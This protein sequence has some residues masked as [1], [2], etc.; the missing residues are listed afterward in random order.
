[1]P[2]RRKV[3]TESGVNVVTTR[4]MSRREAEE[5]LAEDWELCSKCAIYS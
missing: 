1:M 2:I 3:K 4:G 5:R